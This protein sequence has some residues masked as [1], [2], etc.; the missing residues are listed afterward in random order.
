MHHF[1]PHWPCVWLQNE[2]IFERQSA[3]GSERFGR[4]DLS[5]VQ[6][7]PPPGQEA[8]D[9]RN[10]VWVDLEIG[11]QAQDAGPRGRIDVRTRLYPPLLQR[12][13]GS[14]PLKSL[15]KE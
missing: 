8:A 4:E 9:G 3:N 2:G 10:T 14:A 13:A 15:L 6:F 1:L 12:S 5:I 7:S 11:V